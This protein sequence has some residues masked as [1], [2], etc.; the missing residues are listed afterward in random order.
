[1]QLFGVPLPAACPQKQ[2]PHTKSLQPNP[3]IYFL[4]Y[5]CRPPFPSIWFFSLFTLSLRP[6]LCHVVAALE[7]KRAPRDVS[8]PAICLS[9]DDDSETYRPCFPLE[10][11]AETLSSASL[12][13]LLCP[14]YW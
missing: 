10:T 6:V 7:H 14:C 3:A 4:S 8:G 12:V 5:F 13:R 9:A 1:M 2:V 11:A